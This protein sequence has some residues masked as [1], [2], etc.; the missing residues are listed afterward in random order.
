MSTCLSEFALDD[1]ILNGDGEPGDGAAAHLASC[2]GC[3]GRHAERRASL[4]ELAHAQ[5]GPFWQEIRRGYRRRRVTRRA[6]LLGLSCGMAAVLASVVLVGDGAV[7]SRAY[8]GA[9]GAGALEIHC[10]R[11]GRTFPLRPEDAVEPGDELRFVPRPASATVRYVQIA[12][13][14]GTGRY[15][16]FYPSSPAAG[17]LPLPSPGQALDGSIRLDTAP[18]P[19][20]LF[21]V[22]S[23]V[24]LPVSEVEAVARQHAGDRQGVRDIGGVAVESGWIVLAKTHAASGK[25]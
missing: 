15:T 10:R 17:S 22:F 25:P 23:S 1:L 21:F 2:A 9:K 6:L 19:E 16:P 5:V 7:P 20:Q 14:D 18:G 24:S 13:I 11:A 3:R 4:E 12:S 8:L